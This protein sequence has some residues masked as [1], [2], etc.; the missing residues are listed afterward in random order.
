MAQ[1]KLRDLLWIWGMKL[2]ALQE[3]GEYTNL[4]LK[5]S[6]MTTEKAINELGIYNVFLAG[7]LPITQETVDTMPSAKRIVCK[8][9]MHKLENGNHVLDTNNALLELQACKEIAKNDRRIDAF[10][11]DDLSTGG[12]EAGVS[13][14]HFSQFCIQN[15]RVFPYMPLIGTIYPMSLYDQ[16]LPAIVGYLD[17]IL[18]PMWFVAFCFFNY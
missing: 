3:S 16:K 8:A 13:P 7:H 2:N 17:Q 15:A 14:E 6:K 12:M 4:H 18:L 5:R 1:V 10:S 11:I 9:S